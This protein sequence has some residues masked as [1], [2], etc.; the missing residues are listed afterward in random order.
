MKIQQ[1]TFI[2]ILN[3]SGL[4]YKIYVIGI[5]SKTGAKIQ[6]KARPR[7]CIEDDLRAT[8]RSLYL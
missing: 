8:T 2:T 6:R 4:L 5:A 7:I 3:E 1:I